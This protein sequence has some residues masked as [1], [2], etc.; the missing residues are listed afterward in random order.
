ML[1]LRVYELKNQNGTILHLGARTKA[2]LKISLAARARGHMRAIRA[3]KDTKASCRDD[4]SGNIARMIAR[5][6]RRE[7]VRIWR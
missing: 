7:G 5:E 2:K 3:R 6:L 4:S 1:P